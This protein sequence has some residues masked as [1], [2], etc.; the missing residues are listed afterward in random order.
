[1]K[2]FDFTRELEG[3]G[4]ASKEVRVYLALVSLGV[5]TAYQIAQQCDVK[6]PTV[7]VILEDLRKKGLALKVPHAKKALFSARDIAEYLQ[8]QEAKIKSV[9][10]IVP[11]LHALGGTQRSNV[12]FFNGMRGITQA[13][14]YKIDSMRGKKFRGFYSNLADASPEMLKLYSTWDQK[15]VAM[16]ISFDIIMAKHGAGKY[17]KDIIELSKTNKN[18]RIRLLEDYAYPQNQTIDMGEDFLR[19]VDEKRL[20]AT[21]IDD[22]HTAEAMRQIFKI[23]WER[24]V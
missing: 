6:K 8:E 1:M 2:Q 22:K 24:G 10:A 21:I 17:Y 19:I 3:I 9:R 11:Q 23:V 4:L 18:V 5:G 7:Y 12:F 15:T 14:D 16:D 13:V 20:T